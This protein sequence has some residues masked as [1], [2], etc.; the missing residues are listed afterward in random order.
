MVEMQSSI[1]DALK[2][3]KGRFLGKPKPTLPAEEKVKTPSAAPKPIN[4]DRK[5]IPQEVRDIVKD[6]KNSPTFGVSGLSSSQSINWEAGLKP[7]ASLEGKGSFGAFIRVP[8]GSLIPDS[9]PGSYPDGVGVKY[10][11]LSKEELSLLK[12]AGE[13]GIGPKFI[14]A[15]YVRQQLPE[16]QYGKTVHIGAIAMSNVEG[17]QISKIK[18]KGEELSKIKDD[19]LKATAKLHLAG[20]AHNDMHGGNAIHDGRKVTFVDFGLGQQNWKA[21]LSEAVGIFSGS[22]YQSLVKVEDKNPEF[23]KMK[24]NFYNR[25]L[26]LLE[27]KG[28]DKFDQADLMG[29]GIR[30]PDSFY[31]EKL[32]GKMSDSVAKELLSELYHGV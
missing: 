16:E 23:E 9:K 8:E 12:T 28:F 17:R 26:P 7:G 10:G 11:K 18:A 5:A 13:A 14:G 4:L 27:S 6:L 32:F 29:A 30:N 3:L 25:F 31:K 24:N 22:N 2:K 20:I 1:S 19:Y 21:A 15:K